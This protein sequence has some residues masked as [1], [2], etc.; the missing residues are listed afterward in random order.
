MPATRPECQAANE[1]LVLCLKPLRQQ[2]T[3]REELR[4]DARRVDQ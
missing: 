4:Y 2:R 3:L 1:M